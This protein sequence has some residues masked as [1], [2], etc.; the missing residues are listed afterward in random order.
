MAYELIHGKK[1]VSIFF[2]NIFLVLGQ[3]H[4]FSEFNEWMTNVHAPAKKY[5]IYGTPLNKNVNTLSMMSLPRQQ[6]EWY[7]ERG[8]IFRLG[9]LSVS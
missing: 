9:L 3:K 8:L 1:T 2:S 7:I 5:D 6:N 4:G